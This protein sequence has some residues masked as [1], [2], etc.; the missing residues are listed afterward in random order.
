MLPPSSANQIDLTLIPVYLALA[1]A[2]IAT[3]QSDQAV[4][5]LQTYT[6]YA[7]NDTSA[8]LIA[9]QAYNAAGQYQLAV[10]TLSKAIDADRHNAR[11]P[12]SSAADA[13]L[14][15]QEGSLAQADFK[16]A[17]TIRSERF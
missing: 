13:Y 5:V 15:L 16:S 1:R 9:G 7:P 4:S 17:I 10:N 14:N 2:Y 3:G 6:I 12:I 11:M 8:S